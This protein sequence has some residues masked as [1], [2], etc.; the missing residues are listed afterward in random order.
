MSGKRATKE[1]ANRLKKKS[2]S[3]KQGEFTRAVKAPRSYLG[4]HR[5]EPDFTRPP[6][7]VPKGKKAAIKKKLAFL[8]GQEDADKWYAE[9]E[10]VMRVFYAHKTLQMIRDDLTFNPARRFSEKDIILI[11]YGDL[12]FGKRK[13][14]LQILREILQERAKFITTL[15][16]LPFFPSSSDRGFSIISYFAVDPNLGSWEDIEELG[17]DFRLMFDGVINHVSSKS[18]MFQEFLNGN[19]Q[20]RDFFTQ[21]TTKDALSLDHMKL[22]LRPRTSDLLTRFESID[23]PKYVW[24]TFSPDQ[25]DLNFKNINVLLRVL[26]VLLYYVRRGADIIRLDAATYLWEEVGT[27]CAHLEQTH[28]LIQLFRLVLDVVA[29]QVA[30]VTE[31]NVPH[32]DNIRYFGDGTNEAQMVY[33]FALPPLVLFTFHTGNCRNLSRW[34]AGLEHVSDTATYFNFLDAHDG[35]GLLAVKSILSEKEIKL[36]I[37][38]TQEHGGMISYRTDERGRRSPYELNIT[39]YSAIN[40]PNVREPLALQIDRFVASRSIHLVLRGVPGT[41]LP[42]T[43]GTKN[44]VETVLRTG[45]KRDINRRTFDAVAL[46]K[47]LNDRKSRAYR[48]LSRLTKLAIVRVHCPAFH[49]NGEQ[50]VILE[51][52]RVFSLLRTSPDGRQR[53]LALTNVTSEIQKFHLKREDLDRWPKALKNLLTGRIKKVTGDALALSLRPYQVKWLLLVN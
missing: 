45:T 35:V 14:P 10:R 46:R 25:I 43:I 36:L 51:N 34:A 16:I 28:Q 1:S 52:D 48:I 21:F 11:T 37:K 22:I 9:V 2:N 30:L 24:T 13:K 4:L 33:N 49:P 17:Q 8:Y 39:W 15:H 5:K 38:K 41:Y 40:N 19:P 18:L 29:P 26:E 20:Y 31:T 27:T 50:K 53:I 47:L 6:L 23:G 42:T 44:D 7:Q 12:V 32:E 3:R